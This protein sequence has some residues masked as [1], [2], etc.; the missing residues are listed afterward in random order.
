MTKKSYA[1]TIVECYDMN[2]SIHSAMY[3]TGLSY[4]TCTR[5]Y[6]ELRN[7]KSFEDA[8]A[9]TER[10]SNATSLEINLFHFIESNKHNSGEEFQKKYTYLRDQFALYCA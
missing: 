2:L 10:I 8:K 4:Q 5:H 7:K 1:L 6:S 3:Q 9:N